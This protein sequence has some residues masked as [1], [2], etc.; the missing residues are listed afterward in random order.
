MVYLHIIQGTWF[1]ASTLQNYEEWKSEW[2]SAIEFV[3][4]G[5]IEVKLDSFMIGREGSNAVILDDP[6]CSRFHCRISKEGS[7]RKKWFI[8]DLD[9]S[10]G[11]SIVDDIGMTTPLTPRKKTELKGRM[12]IIIGRTILLFEPS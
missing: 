10:H 1:R 6:S 8:E 7:W 4:H 5:M 12:K 2:A 11:T 3:N 9:S